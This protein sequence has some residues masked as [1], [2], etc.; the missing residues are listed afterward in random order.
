[1]KNSLPLD[2]PV[3]AVAYDKKGVEIKSSTMPYGEYLKAREQSKSYTI[4]AY[5]VGFRNGKK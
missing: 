4:L 2:T 5:Q 1:M 3:E